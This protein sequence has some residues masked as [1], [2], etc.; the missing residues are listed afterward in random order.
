LEKR[1]PGYGDTHSNSVLYDNGSIYY[2][3]GDGNGGVRLDISA[4]GMKI[5]Q[6]W[7]NPAFDSYMG[8]IVRFGDFIYGGG[9]TKLE[10]KSVN[11]TTGMLADSLKIG[12]GAVI[13]ADN[14]LYF[15]TQ[16]GDMMLIGFDK[17]K[18]AKISS[19]RITK[20]KKEHFSH[21]VINKG[22]LYQRHGNVLMAFD[23]SK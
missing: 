10:L 7:R 4:D 12:T 8:G 20:G 2:A 17:G 11:T 1:T 16:K 9:T 23:V 5:T 19:F 6:K 14:M 22:I 21:P 3:A 13:A 15:Y 18:L